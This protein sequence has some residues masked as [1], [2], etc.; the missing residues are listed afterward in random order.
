MRTIWANFTLIALLLAFGCGKVTSP[1]DKV[2]DA[3][4]KTT[5]AA[6]GKHLNLDD[7][8]I[9]LPT[10]WEVLDFSNKEIMDGL[11]AAWSKDDTMKQM[12]PQ[13]RAMATNGVIKAFAFDKSTIGSGFATNVNII[14]LDQGQITLEKLIE[15]NK[16]QLKSMA[17]GEV[18]SSTVKGANCDVGIVDWSSTQNGG[19]HFYSCVAT[20][21]TKNFTVTFTS[22]EKE[23]DSVRPIME[24]AI[25]TLELK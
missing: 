18:T 25:K 1:D 10:S 16:S 22:K 5:A 13:V 19:L 8:S 14:V 23:K 12:L 4:S 3:V 20:K 17:S 9:T 15:A 6:D 7:C 2:S 21:G 24:A 11:E